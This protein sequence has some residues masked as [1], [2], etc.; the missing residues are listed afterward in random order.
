MTSGKVYI[1]GAG[2]GDPSLITVKGQWIL[3]QADVVLVDHLV[4][5]TLLSYCKDQ[6]EIIYVG[7][8]KG[9]HSITQ[10]AINEKLVFYA[11]KHSMIVR[12]KGGD[13]FIFGRV[14]EELNCLT[15]HSIPFEVIPGVSS[16]IAGPGYAGIPL[17][18]RNLS[19]S[20]AFVTGTLKRDQAAIDIPAADTLVFLMGFYHL[21]ELVKQLL[22]LSRFNSE[23]PIAAI[24]KAS[25]ADQ[26]TI[27]STL[28]TVCQNKA[29]QQLQTPVLLVVG[30]V[31]TV[32]NSCSFI[33]SLPLFGHRI[34]LCRPRHQSFDWYQKLQCLGADVVIAPFIKTTFQTQQAKKL[35]QSFLSS[36]DIICFTSSNAVDYFFQALAANG[37][38]SRQ[39]AHKTIAAIGDKT[40]TSLKGYS[41]IADMIAQEPSQLGLATTLS[42]NLNQSHICYPTSTK[43]A[44]TLQDICKQHGAKVTRLEL[45][46]TS[47]VQ[48][49]TFT[50][51][52]SDIIIFSSPSI[53]DSFLNVYDHYKHTI[54]AVALGSTTANYLSQHSFSN[55]IIPDS[56]SIDSIVSAIMKQKL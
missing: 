48:P 45:Y 8:Q 21:T 50:V 27:I 24:S 25:T 22:Q 14:G 54:Y 12:L 23:T 28:G 4:H 42:S 6:A 17:T 3:S 16:A 46:D 1:I 35:T 43:A 49:A 36:V 11:K 33:E 55:I 56:P 5:P 9:K 41:I 38:D 47:F 7:K 13:P 32:Q 51:Q 19:R 30:S 2:P 44:T 10:K 34:I 15:Q 53:V 52:Q 29:V 18:Y 39:L 20:V 26:Q 31:I 37:L 40:A